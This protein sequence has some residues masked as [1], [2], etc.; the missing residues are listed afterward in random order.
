LAKARKSAGKRKTEGTKV[1]P[2]V[3]R[4]QS[5][6]ELAASRGISETALLA[7]FRAS[8][9]VHDERAEDKLPKEFSPWL[10]KFAWTATKPAKMHGR[11]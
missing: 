8:L 4:P 3:P 10:V 5:A 11:N 9:E 7:E 1:E 6:A 2:Y